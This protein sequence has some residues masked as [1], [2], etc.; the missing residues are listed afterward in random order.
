MTTSEF[1]VAGLDGESVGL[2]TTEV[3]SLDS[4]LDGAVLRANDEGWDDATLVW[5][6]M[7]AKTPALVVQPA[8]T[9]DVASAVTFARDKGLLLGIKGGGHNIAGLSMADGGMTLDMSRLRDVQVD[10]DK[11]LVQAG[12]G[13]LLKHVDAATQEHGLATVLGFVSETGL[14]GLTLGGGFGYL[15]RR[16][17]WTTDNLVEVEIV[18][19]DGE[20]KTASSEANPDLF[21]ALR[22][23]GHNFGVVT[24]FTFRLHEVGPAITGGLIAW[25]AEY[26]DQVVT[27]YKDITAAA[28]RELTMAMTMRLAPPMPFIPEEWHG[29][30]IVG[31]IIC[32]SGSNPEA[33]LA[34]L[35]DLPDPIADVVMEKPYTAQQS[36]I[37]MGD[38]KG[39]ERF[40]K[41]EF[42]AGLSD[43]YFANYVPEALKVPTPMSQSVTFH[44]AGRLNEHDDDDGAVGNRDAHYISGFSGTWPPGTPREPVISWVRGSWEKIRRFST[45]GNYVNFQVADDDS[46]RTA[47][48]YG[49]NFERIQRTKAIYDPDNFFRVNRNISP[50]P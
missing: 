25:S 15:T 35:R 17:G 29:K 26:A 33:D 38:P 42:L 43:E 18:T 3:E 40:W 16:F 28:P 41:M 4:R 37:D 39:L 36:M 23:A 45:G 14:A 20:M 8:T 50:A 12:P 21:W 44:L 49:K 27:A 13:C 1:S 2:S 11:R 48:A 5:N 46:E 7:V 10:L 31:F 6:A 22:G 24:R 34:A 30:P 19:A 32:H 9:G 47:A